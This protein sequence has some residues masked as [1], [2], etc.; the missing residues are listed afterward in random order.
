[1]DRCCLLEIAGDDESL[2]PPL[3]NHPLN[4]LNTKA[5]S[6]SSTS[7][8]SLC[9][10]TNLTFNEGGRRVQCEGGREGGASAIFI[11]HLCQVTEHAQSSRLCS[12]TVWPPPSSTITITMTPHMRKLSHEPCCAPLAALTSCLLFTSLAAFKSCLISW[13]I[14]FLSSSLFFPK[15]PVVKAKL[16]QLKAY[17]RL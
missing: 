13:Y 10:L 9:A 15:F 16:Y 7:L 4:G 1:M 12:F 17:M 6:P 5:D 8:P 3:L 11:P 2:F 14:S